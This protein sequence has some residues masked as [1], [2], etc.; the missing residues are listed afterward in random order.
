M[1]L[2]TKCPWIQ[3]MV[4]GVSSPELSAVEGHG[5]DQQRPTLGRSPP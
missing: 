1:D 2:G 4:P 5:A 3:T